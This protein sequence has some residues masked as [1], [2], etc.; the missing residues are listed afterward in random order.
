MSLTREEYI[1]GEWASGKGASLISTW[2]GATGAAKILAWRNVL[3]AVSSDY[4]ERVTAAEDPVGRSVPAIAGDTH[5]VH[6]AFVIAAGDRLREKNPELS[7]AMA[8]DAFLKTPD[9]VLMYEIGRAIGKGSRFEN[10][11]KQMARGYRV[12][13]HEVV[14]KA[15][16]FATHPVSLEFSALLQAGAK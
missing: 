16:T 2:Q 7:R 3:A 13:A 10:H 15:I 1:L 9:G 8:V 4:E 14:T 5:A 11:P 6:G 12:V